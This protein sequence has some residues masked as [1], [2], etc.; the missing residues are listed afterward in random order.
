MTWLTTLELAGLPGM[1]PSTYRTRELL[2]RLSIPKRKREG[3]GGGYEYDTSH[4]PSDTRHALMGRQIDEA[5]AQALPVITALRDLPAE[6]DFVPPQREPEPVDVP[7]LPEPG[8]P[9]RTIK[10]RIPPS[11]FEKTVADARLVLVRTMLD[12]AEERGNTKA[13]A[14]LAYQLESGEA[15]PELLD[16]A[17]MANQRARGGRDSLAISPRS[18]HRWLS[19]WRAEGWWGLLPEAKPFFAPA[20]EVD[21]DVA[22]VLALYSSRDPQYRNMSRAA[23]DITKRLGRPYD[24]WKTLAQ[25][26][27]RLVPKLNQIDLV[28]ARHSGAERAAKLPFKRRDTSMLAPLDVALIDGHTFKAKVRHP[29]HGAPFAPEVTL[30]IDAASRYV[31]GWSVALSENQIA[32]GDALRHAVGNCGVPAVV[33]SD[34]GAGETAKQMDCPITGVMHRLGCDHRTGIPGHPQGHGLIERSWQTHMINCARQFASYQGSDVDSNS[35]R[36]VGAELAKE[37]RAIARAKETG[38]VIQLSHKAPTWQQFMDAVAATI[39]EY[40]T[41]HRHR[42]LPKDDS[43]QHMTPA[44]AW[45]AMLQPELQIRMDALTLRLIFMPCVLRTA[46]RGEVTFLNQ[47]Y[48]SADLMQVEG[49]KV[50]VHYDLHNPAFVMIFSCD[51]QWVCDAHWNAN[52]ID[53]M[54]K[55]VIEMAR[56]KR[57]AARLKLL[58]GHMDLARRELGRADAD[59]AIFSLPGT[60]SASPVLVPTVGEVADSWPNK[61]VPPPAQLAQATAGRPSVFDTSGD[62]YEWLMK[63]RDQ[64]REGDATWLANY[65]ASDS[66]TDLIDY[67]ALRNLLWKDEGEQGFRGAR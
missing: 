14:L 57:V 67:Y 13:A 47:T 23:V 7:A 59:G 44:Q 62:R 46:R 10:P 63:H 39:L 51:N 24:E 34:N 42:S 43:G 35:L 65:V 20:R 52:R 19:L 8:N 37:Q 55:P 12:L 40:N 64:W 45:E 9:V 33:Y 1:S 18:L 21:M 58:E 5:A 15:R 32:V 29:E 4:L 50:R 48:A 66:Y 27:R 56:E 49:E 28:K 54:P 3:R 61:P 2:D 60:E 11:H 22:Q 31:T 30:V 41:Q 38:Q 16:M 25:R 26:A 53:Y 6:T 17:R 36:K